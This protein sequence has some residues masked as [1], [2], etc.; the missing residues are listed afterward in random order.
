MYLS[1]RHI[2]KRENIHGPPIQAQ[3]NGEIQDKSS[4]SSPHFVAS[5]FD[6]RAV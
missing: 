6:L 1:Y 2:R 3:Q 4:E 5:L